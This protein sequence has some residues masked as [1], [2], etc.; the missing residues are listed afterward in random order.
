MKR[1]VMVLAVLIVTVSGAAA[2]DWPQF[3]G[4]NRD[5]ISAETGLLKSW[6]EGGPKR[7]WE[8]EIGQGFSSVAV[9]DN[10]VYA[11]GFIGGDLMVTA[12]DSSGKQ[13]WQKKVDKAGGGAGKKGARSTPTIDGDRLYLLTEDG[14]L[15]C[16]KTADGTKVWAKNILSEYGAKNIT[17]RLAESV[18]IDGDRVI[19]APGGRAALVAL[20]KMTGDEVWATEPIDAKTNYASAVIIEAG[21]LR[22]IVSFSQKSVFGVKADTGKLLW[23]HTHTTSYDVNA[24]SVVFKDGMIFVTSGYG[25]GSEGLKLTV[26]DGKASVSQVWTNKDLDDH[27]G[28]VILLGGKVYG[29][30]FR[31]ALVCID[32]A[33]G[34]TVYKKREV[35]KAS[36]IHADGRLY[37]QGHDGTVQLVDPADGTVVS[38][39]KIE[40]K[41]KNRMW[42]H[43]A[44]S[45]GRL[46]IHHDETL[47]VYDI[48]AK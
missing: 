40:V 38:S 8:Y 33:S 42:A 24:T 18:L 4:I 47:T 5:G 3:R 31:R 25:S 44:I 28:G 41:E 7:L 13:R 39:F 48:K 9:V 16:L 35:R 6:P 34:N 43:P 19:C 17:W 21:G 29:T 12:L 45:D 23:K 27:F 30:A 46:Y 11:T 1:T 22:Q 10:T 2:A 14:S 20:N 15:V 32:L 26:A 37:C 36:N